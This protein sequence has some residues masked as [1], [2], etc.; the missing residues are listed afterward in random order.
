MATS[1]DQ[2]I[3]E[4]KDAAKA[5]LGKDISAMR[6]FSERQLQALA[7]QAIL[8]ESGILSGQITAETREF[9]LDSLEQM[10]LNF[11]NTLRGLVEITIEK[12]WNAI[13]EAIWRAI[14][15]AT[16]MV[17]PKPGTAK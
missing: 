9:F 4:I 5:I 6:G 13:V 7:Q 3:V 14:G 12:V 17:L 8:V 2:L 11:V 10:A 16:G 15:A 1:V